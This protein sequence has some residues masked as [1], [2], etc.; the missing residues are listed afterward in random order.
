M[1]IILITD[2]RGQCKH[3]HRDGNPCDI[4]LDR[5]IP[6]HTARVPEY[7]TKATEVAGVS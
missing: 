2:T 1:R 3:T 4:C 5:R 6:K 7:K